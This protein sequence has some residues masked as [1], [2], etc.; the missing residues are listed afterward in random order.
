MKSDATVWQLKRAR[1]SPCMARSMRIKPIR[2][3]SRRML[4][5]RN[6]S[7][8]LGH[9]PTSASSRRYSSQMVLK[10]L[11]WT[12][13]ISGE[14]VWWA[15]RCPGLIM[16]IGV[17][18]PGLSP[19]ERVLYHHGDGMQGVKRY[20]PQYNEIFL[21]PNPKSIRHNHLRHMMKY[22]TYFV[23]ISTPAPCARS[24]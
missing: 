9:G 2:P 21:R 6:W 23:I 13:V 14:S 22:F 1:S 16:L 3:T 7:P 19:V 4:S 15:L 18:F 8:L 10:L 20:I 17:V 24:P 11:I 12:S 5:N